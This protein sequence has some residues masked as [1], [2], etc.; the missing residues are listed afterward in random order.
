MLSFGGKEQTVGLYKTIVN[1]VELDSA[2]IIVC[3]R[4]EK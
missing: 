1:D 2:F 3:E 4:I